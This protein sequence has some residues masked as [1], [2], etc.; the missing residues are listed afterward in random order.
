VAITATLICAGIYLF[1]GKQK[2]NLNEKALL[3]GFGFLILSGALTHIFNFFGDYSI[4]GYY[5]NHI[6]YSI[7]EDNNLLL[8]NIEY[9]FYSRT[10]IISFSIGTSIAMFVVERNMKQ[11]MYVFTIC[12]LIIAACAF[13]FPL[14]II[15][16]LFYF[17]TYINMGVFFIILYRLTKFSH[18]ELKA[19]SSF[20][21]V[22]FVFTIN[23]NSVS[24]FS[25]K[26][27]ITLIMPPVYF[28]LGA[29][30]MVIPLLKTISKTIKYWKILGSLSVLS[31]MIVFII[32]LFFGGTLLFIVSQIALNVVIGLMFYQTMRQLNT[33]KGLEPVTQ[34]S[35]FLGIFSRPQQLTEEE[36]SVSKEKHVCLVC[37]GKVT[38]HTF[39]CR[40]CETFYCEKCFH[41][42]VDIENACWACDSV[43]DRTKP[44]NLIKRNDIKV[45]ITPENVHKKDTEI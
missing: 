24:N 7:V 4:P 3:Y 45:E 19:I 13:M 27:P 25:G 8:T 39:I 5:T 30:L 20:L 38:G 32:G 31:S 34:T 14:I 37:K 9:E 22:G 44:L 18:S 40:E 16:A 42:L 33:A 41:A 10:A 28:I 12:N 23:A 17:T 11:T 6:F 2:S 43:L 1:R 35:K 36:V 21:F 26:N 29:I 15:V